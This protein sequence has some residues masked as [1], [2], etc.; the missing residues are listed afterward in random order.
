M[1][2][3]NQKKVFRYVEEGS[4]LKLKSFLRKHKDVELNFTKGKKHRSMLHIVCSHGDDAVLRLLLKHGADP[5]QTDRNGDTPLHLA[6]KRALKHGKRCYDDLVVPL[7]RNCPEA[8]GI[9]NK[10]GVTPHDLLQWMKP[11][12]VK[13]N[14]ESS[15]VDHEQQWRE[16]LLGEYQEEF[17]ETFGQYDGDFLWDDKDEEDFGDW[18][19]RIRREYFTKQRAREQAAASSSGHKNSK[20]RK[21][22]KED[23]VNH[24]E[25]RDRLQR[26]HEEYLQ[27]AARKEE[28]T[29]QGKKRRYE[30]RCATTFH[31]SSNTGPEEMLGYDDIPWPSSRGSLEEMVAVMLHG[32]DRTDVPA[33]RK[34]LR[35]QQA[36]WHPDKFVQRCG[37]RL[38]DSERKKILDTVTGLSQELNRLAQSLR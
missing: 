26:E 32:A 4:L 3:R 37:A 14:D 5:R 13:K 10:A 1:V 6:A 24:R 29:R 27:R 7:R 21:E 17:S 15:H 18:A 19:D 2:K 20:R 35:R 16:K 34:I 33:F 28:E 8:M 9:P 11:K 12:Q 25:L 23:E 22:T 36:L 30:E 31:G 38:L